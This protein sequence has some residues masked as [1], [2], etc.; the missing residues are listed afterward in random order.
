MTDIQPEG[1]H[2]QDDHEHQRER[3]E[4]GKNL[5]DLA[6]RIP[7]IVNHR[8]VDR[9]LEI[10]E[11]SLSRLDRI[12]NDLATCSNMANEK[13]SMVAKLYKKAW[14]QL[15]ESKRDLDYIHKRISEMKN[16]LRIQQPDSSIDQ[17]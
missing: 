7:K 16:D 10:Q 3:A 15:A 2:T 14:R 13:Y 5:G 1:D 6:S 8:D 12:N 4:D 9:M 11:N 17:N